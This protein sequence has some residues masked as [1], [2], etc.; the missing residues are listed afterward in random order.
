MSSLCAVGWSNPRSPTK[1]LERFNSF[2]SLFFIGTGQRVQ[3][4][5]AE[6][7]ILI[8]FTHFIYQF[9]AWDRGRKEM[10][11]VNVLK[12]ILYIFSYALMLKLIITLRVGSEHWK[13]VDTSSSSSSYSWRFRHVS[14]SL[15]LQM[16]L[17]PPSLPRLSYVPSSLWFIL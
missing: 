11:V 9:K 13:I 7:K 17:V 1:C 4:A 10:L 16:K 12:I 8:L 2:R 14:C 6:E 3:S 5:R 15:I